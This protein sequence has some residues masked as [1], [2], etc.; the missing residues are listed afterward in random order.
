[1]I[2]RTVNDW[3]DDHAPAQAAALAYY[4]LFSIAPLLIIAVAIA[5]LLFG[6]DAVRGEVHG[7]LQG[8]L[9][10]ESAKIIQDMMVSASNKSSGVIATILGTILLVFAATSVFAQLQD[11]LNAIWKVEPKKMNG[12]LAFLRQRFVSASMVMGKIG[13]AHV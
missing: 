6:K 13:R 5:G 11:T 12:V 4:T 9:G 3:I 7:Q 1:M 2:K 10:D 8:L